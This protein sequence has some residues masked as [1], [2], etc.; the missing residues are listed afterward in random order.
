MKIAAFQMDM[1]WE[2]RASNYQKVARYARRARELGTSLLVLPE[3]FATGFSRDLSVTAEALDGPTISFL[4]ELAREL[5]LALVGGLVLWDQAHERGLNVSAAIAPDGEI[6]AIYAKT[7]LFS[8]AGEHK[9]HL[10][11]DRP[12]LFEHQGLR[13]A[14]L[15]CY[16]LRFPEL[17]RL[18][19]GEVD[20]FMV[21]ASWPRPR[22]RNWDILLPARAVEN[23]AW[24]VG[25]N[26]VGLGDGMEYTGGSGIWDPL[27]ERVA[28]AQDHEELILAD[29]DRDRIG[30]IRRKMPFLADRRYF[31]VLRQAP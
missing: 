27:G 8:M 10:A 2:D 3:M 23:Q 24:V 12:V 16:D 30:E 11:G 4:R 13:C 25:V 26:R 1:A 15:V 28:W 5:D 14:C 18:V 19:A 17:F 21:I 9:H 6:Q 20:L 22:Q 29:I 7:H 31:P